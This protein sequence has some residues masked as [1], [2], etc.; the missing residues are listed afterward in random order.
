MNSHSKTS[1]FSTK[2]KG[3]EL[4]IVIIKIQLISK[5]YNAKGRFHKTILKAPRVF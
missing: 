5:R 1:N 4:T 3:M 2:I